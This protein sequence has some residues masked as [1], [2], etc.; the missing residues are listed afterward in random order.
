[1]QLIT[2]EEC[3]VGLLLVGIA[4]GRVVRAA[5]LAGG[6]VQQSEWVVRW[7]MRGEKHDD[8]VRRRQRHDVVAVLHGRAFSAM[9]GLL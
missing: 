4:L 6:L 8:E 9:N 7:K 1:V 2:P 3:R 5:V